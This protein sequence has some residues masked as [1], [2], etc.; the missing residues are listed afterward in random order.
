MKKYLPI[1]MTAFALSLLSGCSTNTTSQYVYE[2]DEQQLE[3][4]TALT[5]TSPHLGHVV[6]LNPPKKR[7]KV[8]ENTPQP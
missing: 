3:D 4:A 6:W 7:V 5:R 1:V 2:I 8:D